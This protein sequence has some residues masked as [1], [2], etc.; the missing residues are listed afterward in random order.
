MAEL[1]AFRRCH[2]LDSEARDHLAERIRG[3][4]TGLSLWPET[5][6][7]DACSGLDA[8]VYNSEQ[9]AGYRKVGRAKR[10]EIIWLWIS[11]ACLPG[12]F[13]FVLVSAGTAV[14]KVKE[15]SGL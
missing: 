3:S 9:S 8:T 6:A 10:F 7:P 11:I 13:L 2:G 4:Y 14:I 5:L 1:R 12:Q 15:F